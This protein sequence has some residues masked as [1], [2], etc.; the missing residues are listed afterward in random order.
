MYT[1]SPKDAFFLP[2]ILDFDQN[3]IVN[4]LQV[5]QSQI[6]WL[7]Q[8]HQKLPWLVSYLPLTENALR[9]LCWIF[10]HFLEMEGLIENAHNQH[11]D[12]SQSE[13]MVKLCKV[14]SCDCKLYVSCRRKFLHYSTWHYVMYLFVPYNSHQSPLEWFPERQ[15][16]LV[17]NKNHVDLHI[18]AA[19][20]D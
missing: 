17:Q 10:I 13:L 8:L 2:F 1:E 4:K 12:S 3:Y 16:E 20:G 7:D 15:P 9:G 6:K 11:C 5:H 14:L 19:V 18:P